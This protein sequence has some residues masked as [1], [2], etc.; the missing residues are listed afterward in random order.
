MSPSHPMPCSWGPF[1][2][3]L[4]D[5][6]VFYDSLVLGRLVGSAGVPFLATVSPYVLDSHSSRDVS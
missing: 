6:R 1:W 3:G 2:E 4:D 5:L